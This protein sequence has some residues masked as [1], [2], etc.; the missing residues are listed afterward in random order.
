MVH[1]KSQIENFALAL[2]IT[3]AARGI[4]QQFA[5]QQP[6][7]EK[8]EQVRL[9]TL[10]VCVVNDYLQMMGILCDLAASDS[11]NPVMRLCVDVADVE[12]TGVGRLECRPIKADEQTCYIPPEVWQDR[13]GYVVVQL[14]EPLREATVLGFAPTAAM[15]ELPISQLQ[16]LE[17][18][19]DRLSKLMQPQAASKSVASSTT[20]VNLSQWLQNVFESGWQTVE[21]VLVPAQASL[22]FSYRKGNSFQEPDSDHFEGDV[23]RARLIDLGM[24]LAGHS[25][26]LLVELKPESEH[27]NCI[28]LQVHPTGSYTYLPPLIQLIVFDET[29]AVFLQAQSRSTD[30]Y[31][32]LQFGG[33]PGERFSVKV[34][35]GDVGIVENFMI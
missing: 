3:Q 5:Q 7:P 23:R 24:Q 22:A 11:W 30:N 13:I 34:S 31:I 10:A 2:P 17:D 26:A 29:G 4:A 32:Q 8:V 19:L 14:D 9:N 21:A 27:K 35:L 1:E 33:K 12:V 16:P 15:E 18:L 28:R 20:V 6:T 25:V